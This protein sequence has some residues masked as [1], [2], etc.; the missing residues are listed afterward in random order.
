MSLF[1]SR[2]HTNQP[3]SRRTSRSRFRPSRPRR[4]VS[5]GVRVFAAAALIGVC[6]VSTALAPPALDAGNRQNV[7]RLE[8]RELGAGPLLIETNVLATKPER[9][10]WR[11]PPVAMFERAV[12]AGPC[13]TDDISMTP[14]ASPSL[15]GNRTIARLRQSTAAKLLLLLASNAGATIERAQGTS[16]FVPQPRGSPRRI[17]D[18]PN[19]VVAAGRGSCTP[20]IAAWRGLN[21]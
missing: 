7:A 15:A 14:S 12:I 6:G 10:D 11:Q 2:P 17:R 16:E 4:C 20:C 1:E 8:E 18:G 9:L 13:A 5:P 3:E 21:Y 19:L